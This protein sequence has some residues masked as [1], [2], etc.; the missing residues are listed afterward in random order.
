MQPIFAQPI[1]AT[2]RCKFS[3]NS[4]II[5]NFAVSFVCI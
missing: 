5:R 2:F 3:N 1:F 4:V